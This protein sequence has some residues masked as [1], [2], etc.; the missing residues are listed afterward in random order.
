MVV[1]G[2]KADLEHFREVEREKAER[3]TTQLSAACHVDCSAC[4]SEASVRYAFDELCR[5]VAQFRHQTTHKRERRRSSLSTMRQNLKN[6]VQ[7]GKSKNNSSGLDSGSSSPVIGANGRVGPGFKKGNRF[8]NPS[9]PYSSIR[10]ASNLNDLPE[11]NDKF[12]NVYSDDSDKKSGKSRESSSDG[13]EDLN[14]RPS[15][16]QHRNVVGAIVL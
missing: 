7:P 1:V 16:H 12:A 3:I 13:R 8:C 9:S 5:E 2:N 10:S 6:L 4:G 14:K 15:L 11:E